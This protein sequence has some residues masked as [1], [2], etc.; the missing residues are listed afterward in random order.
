MQSKVAEDDESLEA[1]AARSQLMEAIGKLTETYLQWR[2]PDTLHIEEKL[3]FIFGAYWKHTTDTPRGL[4]DE[5]R[6]ML[7][8]G[9]YV[10]GELKKAGIQDWAACAV[11]YVR[12]L[13]REMGY[14]LY[15]PGKTELKWGK[16]VMLP[17]QFT[18][19]TPGKIYHDRDD[20]QKA[21]WQVLLMHVVHPSGATEDAFG[22]LLKDIDAL[23][24]GRNT[25]AHGEHV[26]SSL[27]EEVRDAVLGQMQAGN[28]GVLVR[29]VA[30]LN[31]PA[32][33][34]SSSIG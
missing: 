2:K 28:A 25:I 19:G 14:R 22:H 30:M 34:T 33:G 27:A 3:E 21:N 17:G 10:R 9:E 32:P 11:Q 29:L 8:S 26:A 6:Q 7:I 4:A 20:Q 24:E 1:D 13:E 31:T 23:R 16:K 18:F 5:V 15:E 12:A